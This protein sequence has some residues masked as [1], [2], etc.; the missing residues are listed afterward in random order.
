MEKS[1]VEVESDE[2]ESALEPRKFII[3]RDRISTVRYYDDGKPFIAPFITGLKGFADGI[4]IAIEHDDGKG[5]D[6]RARKEKL[7]KV[8]KK[9]F[10]KQE[11]AGKLDRKSYLLYLKKDNGTIS[12]AEQKEKDKIE[13]K[14]TY[15]MSE[16]SQIKHE[17]YEYT[18]K[19]SNFDGMSS[20]C[21]VIMNDSGL[22][23]FSVLKNMQT[24]YR[25]F[26]ITRRSEPYGQKYIV[27]GP[28]GYWE[29]SPG[30]LVLANLAEQLEVNSFSMEFSGRRITER[31]KMR[32]RRRKEA[33]EREAREDA[34][35]R[36]ESEK[37]VV[38]LRPPLRF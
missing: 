24:L 37:E 6:Y 35:D 27:R 3:E 8:R 11:E 19:D 34:K 38:L 15:L 13:E 14:L 26:R 33:K 9:L 5:N 21:K 7:N 16:I 20:V 28:S 25:K 30:V 17:E 36:M 1:I 32:K 10:K 12:E 22:V 31:E 2:F 23:E 18:S 29:H 4:R